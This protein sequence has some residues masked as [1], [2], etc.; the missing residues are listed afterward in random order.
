MSDC[1]CE[2][3]RPHDPAPTYTRAYMLGCL[4]REIAA[5]PTI[6]ERRARIESW[7]ERQGPEMGEVLKAAIVRV[8]GEAPGA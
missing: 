6:S 8:F 7:E 2:S 3:C 5:L 1:R 4:A